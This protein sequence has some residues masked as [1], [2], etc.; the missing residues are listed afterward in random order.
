LQENQGWQVQN[1]IL[2]IGNTNINNL[3]L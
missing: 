3:Q 1:A 2:T